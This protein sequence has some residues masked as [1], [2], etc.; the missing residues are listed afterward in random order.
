MG[1]VGLVRLMVCPKLARLEGRA[2]LAGLTVRVS[3][4]GLVRLAGKGS[5]IGSLRV[6]VRS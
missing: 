3:L 5:E 4:T 6:R 2:S 1:R